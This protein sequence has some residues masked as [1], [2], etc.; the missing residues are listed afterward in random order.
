M[1][2]L[3]AMEPDLVV[4]LEGEN[5]KLSAQY[6]SGRADIVSER[7]VDKESVA[8]LAAKLEISDGLV[9]EIA[10]QVGQTARRRKTPGST[11]SAG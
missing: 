4:Y 10:S 9:R 11:S 7:P 3:R 2:V 5:P 6:A 8:A 1:L